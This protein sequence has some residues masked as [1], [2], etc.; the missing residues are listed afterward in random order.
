MSPLYKTPLEQLLQGSHTNQQMELVKKATYNAA[1]YDAIKVVKGYDI[2]PFQPFVA[3]LISK[4]N[5]LKK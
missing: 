1:I 4:L 2:E 3:N 5:Q